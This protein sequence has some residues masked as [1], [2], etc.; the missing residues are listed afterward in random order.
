MIGTIEKLDMCVKPM[1]DSTLTPEALW[2]GL[3]ISTTGI[4]TIRYFV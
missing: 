1:P 3:Q 2:A 4:D